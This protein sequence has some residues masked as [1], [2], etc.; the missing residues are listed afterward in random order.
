MAD[1]SDQ[2]EAHHPDA[3]QVMPQRIDPDKLRAYPK[4]ADVLDPA[5]PLT[6]GERKALEWQLS[7][8][9]GFFTALFD[10]MTKCDPSNLDRLANGF[11]EYV[12][13][14]R[15]YQGGD[16]VVKLERLG[17]SL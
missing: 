15:A 2:S 12:Q 1:F 6:T 8:T 9:G 16:L 7:M 4:L 13:G 10:L 17:I 5:G 3:V 11:P 14:Y